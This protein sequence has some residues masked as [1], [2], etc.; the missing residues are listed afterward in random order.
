MSRG[1][2]RI[3][4]LE[5]VRGLAA[6]MV[7]VAHSRIGGQHDA[8]LLRGWIG[9]PV[10]FVLSG[11]V[12]YLPFADGTRMDMVAFWRRRVCRILPG[13]W[14]A[15]AVVAAV[16]LLAGGTVA[17]PFA[18]ASLFGEFWNGPRDGDLI[19]PA[20]TL[21]AEMVFYLV[22]PLIVWVL[23]RR[24]VLRPALLLAVASL[25][26]A[27]RGAEQNIVPFAFF[28][29]FVFGM[30]AAILIVR[31][32]RSWWLAAAGA[33]VAAAA[34]VFADSQPERY[35]FGELVA[36]AVALMLV[37]LAT[38]NP[39]VPRALVGLGTISFGVYLWH[40]PIFTALGSLGWTT[41]SWTL[42]TAVALMLTVAVATVSYRVVERPLIRL[43][44]R[45]R[46]QGVLLGT[47]ATTPSPT[48]KATAAVTHS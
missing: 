19:S 6:V 15:L 32:V 14:V 11:L 40:V 42:N 21:A 45:S 26:L 29:D 37:P 44:A 23:V 12:L 20:W 2:G 13:Y 47:A 24:P 1:A 38:R 48:R 3:G 31:G 27:Y 28:G 9:V 43:A 33:V 5:A 10:F 35:P 22:L 36:L 4:S 16:T 8:V 18:Q 17:R 41:G 25:A 34:V 46:G 39:R 7:L 30:V